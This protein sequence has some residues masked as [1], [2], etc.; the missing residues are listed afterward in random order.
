MD[1]SVD[2][3]K[4]SSEKKEKG[5]KEEENGCQDLWHNLRSSQVMPQVLAN[6]LTENLRTP[7]WLEELSS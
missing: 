7:G 5:M 2:K 1:S 3:L 4:E 6:I